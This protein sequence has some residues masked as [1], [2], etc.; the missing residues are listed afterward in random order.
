M[1]KRSRSLCVT[2]ARASLRKQSIASS[3]ASTAL[4]KRAHANKAA[5][6]LVYPSSNT[7]SNPMVA[8]FGS[9]AV[10]EKERPF[11]SLCQKNN[12]RSWCCKRW[13]SMKADNPAKHFLL[14][15]LIA[16]AG[17]VLCYE[18]IQ[19]WRTRNGPWQVT[20]LQA[21]NL[22]PEISIQQPK[23]GITN[24]KIIFVDEIATNQPAAGAV[25][26]SAATLS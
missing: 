24:V 6:A 1:A 23:L 15:F 18:T 10:S 13:A 21:A 2:M 22:V 20:F 3:S 25:P 7:S 8:G 17:Y 19:H 4:I 5:P 9:R 11:S 16:L 26:G 12:K 14:A